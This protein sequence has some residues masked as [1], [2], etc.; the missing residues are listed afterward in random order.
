M[1]KYLLTALLLLNPQD[2]CEPE[3]TEIEQ[4]RV[5]LELTTTELSLTRY[6]LT[7]Q[8]SYGRNM[9][10][11]L[12][13]ERYIRPVDDY[14]GAKVKPSARM[15]VMLMPKGGEIWYVLMLKPTNKLYDDYL[16]LKFSL[17]ILEYHTDKGATWEDYFDHK[18]NEI[19][20]RF[21]RLL[22]MSLDNPD[23]CK[24]IIDG[25]PHL[26]R[27]INREMNVENLRKE[28]LIY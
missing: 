12:L 20:L 22:V 7:S 15:D 16:Y 25:E 26:Y 3:P 13:L 27:L 10:E 9:L 14:F 21:E 23:L 19:K 24:T 1:I 2:G 28:D 6:E 4:L 5:Q 8:Y 11:R 18:K 17:S